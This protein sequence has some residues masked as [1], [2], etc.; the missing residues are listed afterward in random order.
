VNKRLAPNTKHHGR[1]AQKEEE[2][3]ETAIDEYM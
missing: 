3:E 1:K 2:E